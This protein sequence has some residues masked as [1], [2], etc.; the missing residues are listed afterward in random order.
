VGQK[1]ETVHKLMV[2]ILSDLNRFLNFVL[3][4][5]T[6]KFGVHWLLTVPQLP[7]Y[8][9]TLPSKTVMSKNKRLTINYKV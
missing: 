3:G 1:S 4:R 5:F 6:G 7:A 9:A 8:V 2:I